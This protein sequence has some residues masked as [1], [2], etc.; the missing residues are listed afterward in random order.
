MTEFLKEE[1]A[2]EGITLFAPLPL[3]SCRILRPYLLEREGIEGGTAIL[4]A[5]PYAIPQNERGNLS[6]Y[7]VSR[8]Y[9]LFFREL[10]DRLLPRLRA[11]YPAHRF[12]G[13]TDHS[14]IDEIHAAASA[15]LGVIGDNG[16]LLTERYSSYIF[17]GEIVTDACLPSSPV[18]PGECHHCGACR[19][20][21][22][23]GVDKSACLSALTQKKGE[24]TEEERERLRAHPLVWGCDT[25]QEVCPYTR[26]AREHGTLYEAPPFFR[27]QALS[28]LTVEA[29]DT[30]TDEQFR[31]RAY[32][33]RGRQVIWRNLLLKKEPPDRT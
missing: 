32:A 16:L 23:V 1:L 25:C 8:D 18:P 3:S 27:E 33:W 10:F 26:A 12:A 11:R 21:C 30:M 17:L 4:M 29:L 2:T 24:L 14:P 20:A 6:A 9:H 15:G 7:A 22:P 28:T 31:T 13:F 19:R 5:V